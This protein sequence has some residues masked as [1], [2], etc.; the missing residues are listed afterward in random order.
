M[1]LAENSFRDRSPTCRPVWGLG[2]IGFMMVGNQVNWRSDFLVYAEHAG[3]S[4][5]LSLPSSTSSR[6]RILLS[7]HDN[8]GTLFR[9]NPC[10][11]STR[12]N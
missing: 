7:E 2:G 5:L 8:L 4:L 3:T 9:N 1:H 10:S 6:G 11:V 12:M